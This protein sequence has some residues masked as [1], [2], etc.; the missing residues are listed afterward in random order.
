MTAGYG[1]LSTDPG[2]YSYD[3]RVLSGLN[4]KLGKAWSMTSKPF[5]VVNPD[6]LVRNCWSPP[7]TKLC[8]TEWQLISESEATSKLRHVFTMAMDTPIKLTKAWP[9][10]QI[11]AFMLAAFASIVSVAFSLFHMCLDQFFLLY[12]VSTFWLFL[13]II[14]LCCCQCYRFWIYVWTVLDLMICTAAALLLLLLLLQLLC[15][16]DCCWPFQLSRAG[17]SIP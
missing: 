11:L 16:C 1:P 9:E 10:V 12:S 15:C 13:L 14:H 3:G 4:L 8:Y 17:E 2:R 7:T 6:S 5:W